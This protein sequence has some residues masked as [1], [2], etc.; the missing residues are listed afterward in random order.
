M[1][2]IPHV[3]GKVGMMYNYVQLGNYSY[4][5]FAASVPFRIF[6]CTVVGSG[7]IDGIHPV[8][9][10]HR[11]RA[12]LVG[13]LEHFL[14]FHILG[15]LTPTDELIFFRGVET[16]NPSCSSSLS[17]L[18]SLWDVPS[19]SCWTIIRDLCHK[20][21]Q[22]AALTKRNTWGNSR[23]LYRMEPPR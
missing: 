16:A 12:H 21:A 4:F 18:D 1:V 10:R 6:N 22:Q 17:H 5:A 20:I 11:H 14:F 2:E 15:I 19:P 9:W 23:A 3:S 8:S 7:G 13:G